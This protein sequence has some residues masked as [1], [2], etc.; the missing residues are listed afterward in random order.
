MGDMKER[1]SGE[2]VKDEEGIERDNRVR[3]KKEKYR[4]KGRRK[5]RR[6]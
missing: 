2:Q 5:K 1:G 4:R 6:R 3:G